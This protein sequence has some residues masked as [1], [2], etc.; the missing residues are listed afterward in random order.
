MHQVWREIDYRVAIGSVTGSNIDTTL[1]FIYIVQTHGST[2]I[3]HSQNK[4]R[5]VKL[6]RI[7]LNRV[8]D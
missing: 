6:C 3:R 7:H 1:T 4:R 2:A 5:K 8:V